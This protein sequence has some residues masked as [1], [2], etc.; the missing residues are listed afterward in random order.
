MRKFSRFSKSNVMAIVVN[1]A[2]LDSES[3]ILFISCMCTGLIRTCGA[4]ICT[5]QMKKNL[6][7]LAILL[8]RKAMHIYKSTVLF[9][10]ILGY[11][12]LFL[13]ICESVANLH[14]STLL[15]ASNI[16]A[17]FC[18]FFV[19]WPAYCNMIGLLDYRTIL[20]I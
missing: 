3:I 8:A 10:P 15:F 16:H 7:K 12:C 2:L 5:R 4:L 20:R 13:P 18:L 19:I 14:E 9:L 11:F 6:Q 17:Y 1:W